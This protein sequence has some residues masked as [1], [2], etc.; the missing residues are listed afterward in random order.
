MTFR[1][2]PFE[3]DRK[4]YRATRDG[5]P[6]DLTSKQLDLLFHF[7]DRPGVLITKEELLDSVWPGANV[8]ENAMAQAISDLREALGDDAAA[9]TFIKTVSRRGYRFV[10]DV[11]SADAAAGPKPGAT[12][13][14]PAPASA[15]GSAASS[16]TAR[17]VV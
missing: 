15:S 17:P 14:T 1:F 4:A 16:D 5:A 2:G 10:A 12:P 7:L 3:A 9:P 11:Q 13:S 6:L 8:T